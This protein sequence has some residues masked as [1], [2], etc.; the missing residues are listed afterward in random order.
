M[1]WSSP[2]FDRTLNDVNL[3][4]KIILRIKNVGF[5]NASA[6][7]LSFFYSDP[8]G[9]YNISDNDRIVNNLNYLKTQLNTYGYN[10]LFS[11]LPELLESDLP[12]YSTVFTNINT[13]YLE[14]V[15]KFYNFTHTPF[16]FKYQLNYEDINNLEKFCDDLNV[17][18]QKMILEFNY[19]GTFYSGDT[20]M[21]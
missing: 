10:I 5:D 16:V 15:D 9:A 7:D 1:A 11:D 4:K 3:L 8:K 6:S 18:I 17:L 2:I 13:A 19:C 14:M 12:F 21:L 20:I